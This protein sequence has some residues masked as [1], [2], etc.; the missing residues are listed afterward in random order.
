MFGS[1]AK[2]LS[3]NK[4]IAVNAPCKGKMIDNSDIPDETFADSI[5]GPTVAIMPSDNT[6]CAPVSGKIIQLFRTKH[7]FTIC[8]Q[9]NV[10]ILVHIGIN[11]VD[12]NRQGFEALVNENDEVKQGDPIIKF[13]ADFIKS[14]NLSTI[15]PMVI[16]NESDFEQVNKINADDVDTH[17]QLFSVQAKK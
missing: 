12:L 10:E 13:D 17:T 2:M 5:L 8:S 11:T 7:A 3:K 14:K 6:V 9:E 16:C 4:D 1:F 15:I